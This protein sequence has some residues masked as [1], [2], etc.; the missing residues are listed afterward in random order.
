MQLNIYMYVTSCFVHRSSSTPRRWNLECQLYFYRWDHRIRLFGSEIEVFENALQTEG[1]W[2]RWFCV[3]V[4]TNHFENGAFG[5]DDVKI[6]TWF[7]WPSLRQTKI[8]DDL[9]LLGFQIY[10][11][12]CGQKTCYGFSEW[13]P[14]RRCV[15]GTKVKYN[16]SIYTTNSCLCILHRSCIVKGNGENR[17][18]W[19][20]HACEWA[21]RFM[22]FF[23]F[24][25]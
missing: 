17:T 16:Q 1:I 21:E 5:N 19:N 11:S 6:I 18:L 4:W 3:L 2:K 20:F 23:F 12:W 9:W 25:F 13:N 24:S 22:S 7:P 10:P 15:D 8:Q 14:V